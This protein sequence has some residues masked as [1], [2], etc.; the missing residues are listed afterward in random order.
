[1]LVMSIWAGM[2]MY[3]SA[4]AGNGKVSRRND[5]ALQGRKNGRMVEEALQAFIK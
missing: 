5:T 1:M 3:S 4:I 2:S